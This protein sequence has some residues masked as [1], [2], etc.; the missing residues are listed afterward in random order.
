MAGFGLGVVT[1]QIAYPGGGLDLPPFVDS[2]E[3]TEEA[4]G[5]Y[6][7][8]SGRIEADRVAQ[9]PGIYR[10]GA[11]WTSYIR[12]TGECIFAGT[13]MPP[14]ISGGVA[15][16]SARGLAFKADRQTNR[17]L[18]QSRYYGDWSTADSDPYNLQNGAW[19]YD[20]TGGKLSINISPGTAV[21]TGNNG[22][23]V[24]A[25][26]SG[27][28]NADPNTLKRIAF[29]M[30]GTGDFEW[31]LYMYT[32]PNTLVGLEGTTFACVDGNTVD[33]N[34]TQAGDMIWLRLHCTVNHTVGTTAE[35]YSVNN[36]K[37]NG[38][39]LGDSYTAAQVAA[40]IAYRLGFDAS[41]IQGSSE[42]VLP[43]DQKQSTFADVL[44]YIDLL[45]DRRTLFLS[46]NGQTD[47][48]DSG[49]WTTRTWILADDEQPFDPIGA[50]IFDQVRVPFAYSSGSA[51]SGVMTVSLVPSPLP[52]PN[53]FGDIAVQSPLPDT[54]TAESMGRAA[55]GW[56]STTRY[57]GTAEAAEVLDADGNRT[58]AYRVRAGDTLY[59]KLG[60]PMRVAGVR[61]T[62]RSSAFTFDNRIAALD[63]L[64]ARRQEQLELKGLVG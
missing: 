34:V 3:A 6:R 61:R 15:Q 27:D 47:V 44:D 18:W 63:R 42:S 58:S 8:A 32:F 17:L 57:S 53:C 51:A 19:T 31:R 7:S 55:L 35:V 12:E 9:Y 64:L 36:L 39:A 46:F 23:F 14:A 13:L 48:C 37:L 40:D 24:F 1:H 52:E 30:H 16:L 10:Q 25:A 5:G 43:L 54:T 2:W 45:Q 50:E 26:P 60:I 38:I 4:P 28:P 33:Y 21:T 11:R 62:D 49:P 41:M 56:L 59:T 22:G 20:N 29:T